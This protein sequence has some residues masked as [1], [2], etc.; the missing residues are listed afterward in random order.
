M[1]TT[2]T[3]EYL[4]RTELHSLTDYARCAEQAAWLL[5]KNI[6]HLIDG[7]RV[8]VS[9]VHVMARLEGRIVAS[10]SGLNLGAIK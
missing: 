7:K 2:P 9:R 5:E 8:I 10:S 3:S 1:N 4:T 6:P